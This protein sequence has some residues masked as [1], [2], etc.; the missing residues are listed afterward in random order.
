MNNNLR[1]GIWSLG[2]GILLLFLLPA[3]VEAEKLF[4]VPDPP[5]QGLNLEDIFGNP[6]TGNNVGIKYN[7]EKN[8]LQMSNAKTQYGA[9]WGKNQIDLNYPF[10]TSFWVY[11]GNQQGVAAD[12]MTFMMQ[13]IG[14]NH[15]GFNG[16]DLGALKPDITSPS[17]G[18]GYLILEFD[19]YYNGNGRDSKNPDQKNHIA[20]MGPGDDTHFNYKSFDENLS[21]G[22]WRKMALDYVP[23]GGSKGTL[24]YKLFDESL[25][26][27]NSESIIFRY[28]NVKKGGP[29]E[30]HSFFPT[31]KVYWGFTASTGAQYEVNALSF[32]EIPQ[33]AAIKTKDTTIYRVHNW[34]PKENFV[35]AT[36]EEKN[37]VSFDDPRISY[38][39]NIDTNKPGVYKV[40]YT[41]KGKT[42]KVDKD[43]TVTVVDDLSFK[44]VP[45]TIDFNDTDIH[46]GIQLINRKD[47]D[48]AITINNTVKKKWKL[49][50]QASSTKDN[51]QTEYP[52]ALT[53]KQNENDSTG[54]SLAAQQQIASGDGNETQPT[55]SWPENKGVLFCF[56]PGLMKANT[57]TST[58]TWT[59]EEVPD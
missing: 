14:S 34:D 41:Y 11:L 2:L 4:D 46:S 39:H 19:T 22:K 10:R 24:S 38:E 59:L 35:S 50:A 9:I 27:V 6:I 1:K 15:L 56:D 32:N 3:S 51:Q 45:P 54:I 42:D 47:K 36:D 40:T 20:F 17:N 57:Y 16:G 12:G 30:D 28:D 58:I 8:V 21:N 52:N 48:W 55:I 7:D 26:L 31:N 43:A 53:F 29:N 23:N 25:N 18:S 5:E 49:L 37:P 33:K 13:T 44:Y